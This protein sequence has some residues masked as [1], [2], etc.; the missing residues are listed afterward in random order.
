MY[1][2][3]ARAVWLRRMWLYICWNPV[4]H[5]YGS[6][7]SY[8]Y[9]HTHAL[10]FTDIRYICGTICSHMHCLLLTYGICVVSYVHTYTAFYWHTVYVWY[11]VHTHA[12]P[13]TDI[14][15]MQ[16]IYNMLYVW[17]CVYTQEHASL[18][19]FNSCLA[20]WVMSF[21]ATLPVGTRNTLA[22]V[23]VDQSILSVP[24]FLCLH[25]TLSD[26]L[27]SYTACRNPEYFGLGECGPQHPVRA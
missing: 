16:H 25:A 6:G 26:E 1:V 17:Y 19:A 21:S 2:G 22:S 11:R 23:S 14:W 7:Q 24:R 18:M 9:V 15:Y 3:L 5:K 12:L 27:L 10:P 13:F 20:R 4:K 8:I